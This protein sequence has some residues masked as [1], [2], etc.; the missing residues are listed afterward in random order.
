MLDLRGSIRGSGLGKEML[1]KTLVAN[2]ILTIRDGYVR[3][4]KLISS[5]LDIIGTKKA[6]TFDLMEALIEVKDGKICTL[7]SL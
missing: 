4:N 2:L 6:Y 3:G 7:K 5:L 1:N